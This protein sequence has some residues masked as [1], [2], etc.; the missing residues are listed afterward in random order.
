MAKKDKPSFIGID[1]GGTKILAAVISPKGKILGQ[2]KAP[3]PANE[4]P[5]G[6]LASITA[7]VREAVQSA[8][9]T[10]ADVGGM[11]IGS[12]GVVDTS[13]GVVR[14]APNLSNWDEVPL[15]RKLSKALDIPVVVGNDVDVATYGEYALGA[16]VGSKS[17]AGIFPGTGIGGALILD[18]KLHVGAR[19][20][21]AEIGHMTLL[22]GGPLC[23]CGRRGC[24]EAIAS[25]TAL[26]RDLWTAIRFGRET[27]LT[28][29]IK[30]DG[31]IRSGALAKAAEAGDLLVLEI[32]LRTGRYLG[33]LA[34]SIANL[35]DPEVIVFG[36]GLI[37]ACGPWMMPTIRGTAQQHFINRLD[38]DK[39]RIEVAT[40]GDNAGVMGAAMLARSA[41]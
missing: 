31:R 2:A 36:G 15:G 30:D 25:R 12:P 29:Y 14:F 24:A 3:T 22:A 8:G 4:G 5:D 6:V 40:L 34:G 26:E 10:L 17:L 33:L 28:E 35:I 13:T 11:G 37:E 32:L 1:L 39:V 21:A 27:I 20:S 19:G 23:G 7:T 16:G 9:L 18:G 38:I 41:N